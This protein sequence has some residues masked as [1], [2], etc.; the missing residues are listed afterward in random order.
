MIKAVMNTM[1]LLHSLGNLTVMSVYFRLWKFMRMNVFPFKLENQELCYPIGWPL[2][3]LLL[4]SWTMACFHFWSKGRSHLWNEGWSP[5]PV[6]WIS[7][8][9]LKTAYT[10][11]SYLLPLKCHEASHSVAF[12][13]RALQMFEFWCLYMPFISTEAKLLGNC[14]SVTMAAV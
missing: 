8:W 6:I 9:H 3:M 10:H 11:T 14:F 1:L 13:N 7:S 12:P 5:N 2:A 4:S